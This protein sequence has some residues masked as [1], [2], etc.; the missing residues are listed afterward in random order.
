MATAGDVASQGLKDILVEA[1]E[2]PLEPDEYA[3]FFTVMNN[4][5]AALEVNGITLGY[6]PVSNVSDE[7]TVPDG[8]I[9]GITANVAIQAAAQYG[10]KVS[11]ALITKAQVGMKAMRRLS[12]NV[13]QTPY[14]STLPTGSG[15]TAYT[16]NSLV[17][18]FY[19]DQTGALISIAGNSTATEIE[20]TNVYVKLRGF[21]TVESYTGLKPDITGRITNTLDSA[22]QVT[23]KATVTLSGETAMIAGLQ[24]YKNGQAAG[25]VSAMALTATPSQHILSESL[26]LQPGEYLELW[27]ADGIAINDITLH[28]GRIKVS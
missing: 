4:Y 25:A 18:S 17:D 11:T 7:M 27:A 16:N 8:A 5:M 21:W 19:R 3:D 12:V 26:T 14:P 20:A 15:N 2:S 28:S 6:T 13:G 1:S 24:M 23:Y 10:G 22:V 9:L